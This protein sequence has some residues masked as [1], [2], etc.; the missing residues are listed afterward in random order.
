MTNPFKRGSAPG[1][2]TWQ[3]QAGPQEARRAQAR[4]AERVFGGLQKVD[5]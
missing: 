1:S 4:Y 3:F 5:P 2:T